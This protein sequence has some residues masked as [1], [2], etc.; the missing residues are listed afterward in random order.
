MVQRLKRPLKKLKRIL[1]FHLSEHQ[2]HLLEGRKALQAYDSYLEPGRYYFSAD[3]K[4]LFK[5][6]LRNVRFLMKAQKQVYP[7][8]ES[9]PMKAQLVLMMVAIVRYLKPLRLVSKPSTNKGEIL[10]FLRHDEGIKIF[11]TKKKQVFSFHE[12]RDTVM[13]MQAVFEQVQ[14]IVDHSVEVMNPE[15]KLVIERLIDI[16]PRRAWSKEELDE[17]LK[18]IFSW[19]QEYFDG[20]NEDSFQVSSVHPW[21]EKLKTHFEFPEL[22]TL[23]EP[24]LSDMPFNAIPKVPLHG[25]MSYCNLLFDGQ[26]YVVTD[27]ETAG[28]YHFF[29][30][31]LSNFHQLYLNTDQDQW[32]KAYFEGTYDE[33]LIALFEQ[34]HETYLPAMRLQYLLLDYLELLEKVILSKE[35]R[36]TKAL[37]QRVLKDVKKLLQFYHQEHLQKT[38]SNKTK[39]SSRHS[40]Y[41]NG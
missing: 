27:F 35:I 28:L 36:L 15:K 11:S 25:D 40:R 21:I 7:V 13:R 34:C 31:V 39:L 29:H 22:F 32:L 16:K 37:R 3:Y 14:E 26:R 33:S 19:H 4:S 24:Y 6:R 41:S 8:K 30:D 18:Q 5:V 12:D 17:A 9:R 23:L 20:L 38:H 1:K 10:M 2:A